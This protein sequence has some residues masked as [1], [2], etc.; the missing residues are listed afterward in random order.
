MDKEHRAAD[1]TTYRLDALEVE[2]EIGTGLR[3][4]R[5]DVRIQG[6]T[7]GVLDRLGGMRLG[8]DLTE[9]EADPIGVI[10]APVVAVV[11]RPALVDG[12]L[13]VERLR[14]GDVVVLRRR[15]ARHAHREGDDAEDTVR[16]L[17]RG[18]DRA[19]HAVAAEPDED[20]SLGV[21]GVHHG[22]DV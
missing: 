15:D 4:H 13:L 3:D 14:R 7:D 20:G 10:T 5:F 18:A 6:P 2:R 9:E 1:G 12:E 22:G 8:R 16:M 21:G 19:P 17:R 11:F